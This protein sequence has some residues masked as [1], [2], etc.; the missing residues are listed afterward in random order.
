MLMLLYAL[1]SLLYRR[2]FIPKAF[3]E[4]EAKKEDD[5]RHDHAIRVRNSVLSTDGM[6]QSICGTCLNIKRVLKN[7][8]KCIFRRVACRFRCIL[9]LIPS[10]S[11]FSPLC[12]ENKMSQ[13]SLYFALW[14]RYWW[15]ISLLGSSMDQRYWGGAQCVPSLNCTES[16]RFFVRRRKASY[17]RAWQCRWSRNFWQLNYQS[18]S[19]ITGR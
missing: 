2:I 11:V 1:V 10:C 6:T 16:L 12:L 17:I 18:V 4:A 19:V 13:F 15:I 8:K 3:E 5:R 14:S 7:V 9:P